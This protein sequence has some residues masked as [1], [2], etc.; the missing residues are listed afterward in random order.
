MAQSSQNKLPTN[1]QSVSALSCQEYYF[2][3]FPPEKQYKRISLYNVKTVSSLV[4]TNVI[5]ND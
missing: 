3:S 4:L 5:L 2:G 1:G